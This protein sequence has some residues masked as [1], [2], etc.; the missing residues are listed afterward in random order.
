LVL[1][2]FSKE[3]QKNI[4]NEQKRKGRRRKPQHQKLICGQTYTLV[5]R[6]QVF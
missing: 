4:V 1:F 3:E 2:G 5:V 6:Q